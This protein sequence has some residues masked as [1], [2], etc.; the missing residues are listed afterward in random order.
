MSLFV[1]TIAGLAPL[2]KA[3]TS[4]RSSR[5]WFGG[6]RQ[7]VDQPTVSMLAAIVCA[8]ARSPTNDARRVNALVRGTTVSTGRRLV[9]DDPVPDA[10]VGAD[11]AHARDSSGV[12]S[13]CS[14]PRSRRATRAQRA[15]EPERRHLVSSARLQP[16]RMSP[17]ASA[18][19][20]FF[21]KPRSRER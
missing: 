5:R 7:R 8:S 10:H 19:W 15:R 6:E 12:S 20:A 18:R 2:S 9:D 3:S 4:S 17:P 21:S 1:S 16:R 14:S 11:V 13:T